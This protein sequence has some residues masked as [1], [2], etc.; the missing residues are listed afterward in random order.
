MVFCVATNPI[1]SVIP[2]RAGQLRNGVGSAGDIQIENLAVLFPKPQAFTE[3]EG[4]EQTSLGGEYQPPKR[5]EVD[6]GSARGIG[7][8]GGVVDPLEEDTE[9]NVSVG[10]RY[11]GA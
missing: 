10:S 11:G 3:E 7:P 9:V 4:V 1:L 8:D 5:L 2:A 6:L